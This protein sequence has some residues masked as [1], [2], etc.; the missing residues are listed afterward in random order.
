MDSKSVLQDSRESEN[1]VESFHWCFSSWEA[2]YEYAE[3]IKG[4]SE[5]K[6]LDEKEK[7]LKNYCKSWWVETKTAV[8]SSVQVFMVNIAMPH[9]LL[10]VS[11]FRALAYSSNILGTLAK[12]HFKQYGTNYISAVALWINTQKSVTAIN[13]LIKRTSVFTCREQSRLGTVWQFI[14]SDFFLR[15]SFLPLPFGSVMRY[16]KVKKRE[17]EKRSL[18]LQYWLWENVN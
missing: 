10:A 9:K 5:Q 3:L 1:T 16:V 17:E 7:L 4:R 8:S 12:P 13:F 2:V 11:N 18:K 15:L 6:S 14:L